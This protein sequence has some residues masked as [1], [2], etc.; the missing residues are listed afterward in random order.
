VIPLNKPPLP[1]ALNLIPPSTFAIHMAVS[2][3]PVAAFNEK[4]VVAA[5]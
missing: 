2:K 5:A 3:R 1:I 4:V